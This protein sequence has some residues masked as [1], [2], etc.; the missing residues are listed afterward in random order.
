MLRK[1]LLPNFGS[2]LL[3]VLLLSC[4]T[5][6]AFAAQGDREESPNTPCN[7]D[8][9]ERACPDPSVNGTAL[10]NE[11]GSI[12]VEG[13]QHEG[14]KAA[15]C[16]MEYLCHHHNQ[17]AVN[18]HKPCID[19][20][21]PLAKHLPVL[22]CEEFLVDKELIQN[23]MTEVTKP[24]AAATSANKQKKSSGGMGAGGVIAIL[25]VVG[26]VGFALYT[27]RGRFMGGSRYGVQ[28]TADLMLQRG[29]QLD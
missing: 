14:L 11:C 25:L 5:P 23:A 10:I 16:Y 12:L 26:G 21:C 4:L 15:E 3:L 24:P 6:V 1:V 28:E 17:D 8:D 7:I 13:G 9:L 27:F 29:R 20:Q 2:I 18:Q 19:V 22:Q